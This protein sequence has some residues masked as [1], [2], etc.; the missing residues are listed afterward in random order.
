VRFKKL[1]YLCTPLKAQRYLKD[2]EE[3]REEREKKYFSKKT[4]QKACQNKKK[5]YF[6]TR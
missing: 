6:C 2:W 1:H 3:I 5:L 4:F